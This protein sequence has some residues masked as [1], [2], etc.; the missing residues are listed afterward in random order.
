MNIAFTATYDEAY[1]FTNYKRVVVPKNYCENKRNKTARCVS[2]QRANHSNNQPAS[3]SK[4]APSA[5]QKL[6]LAIKI[7]SQRITNSKRGVFMCNQQINKKNTEIISEEDLEEFEVLI[8]DDNLREAQN[9]ATPLAEEEQSDDIMIIEEGPVRNVR[10]GVLPGVAPLHI[11]RNLSLEYTY[12]T[13][14]R[15]Q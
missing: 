5:I 3:R 2:I 6:K 15:S 11:D 4:K 1:V 9:N 10:N 13:D 12:T 7:E 8:E 14:V